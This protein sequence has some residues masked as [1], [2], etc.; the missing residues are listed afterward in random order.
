MWE[1]QVYIDCL[2]EINAKNNMK[3]KSRYDFHLPYY[4]I[5]HIVLFYT[6]LFQHDFEFWPQHI[7][8]INLKSLISLINFV[9]LLANGADDLSWKN[10][11]E[12]RDHL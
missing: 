11:C 9:Q 8:Q 1:S 10:D 12:I 3:Q 6:N 2:N 4:W 7:C 5:K